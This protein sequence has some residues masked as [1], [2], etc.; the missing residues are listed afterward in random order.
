MVD[1][2]HFL[3]QTAALLSGLASL[4]VVRLGGKQKEDCGPFSTHPPISAYI[5][6][7]VP[8]FRGDPRRPVK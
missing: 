5:R 7:G 3:F 1:W 8:D 4:F 6:S 2:L